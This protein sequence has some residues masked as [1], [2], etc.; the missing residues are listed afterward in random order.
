[1]SSLTEEEKWKKLKRQ[2]QEK[3]KKEGRETKEKEK[4]G[5]LE[6][7]KLLLFLVQSFTLFLPFF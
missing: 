6:E 5:H 7:N 4:T 3:K 2:E 1:M